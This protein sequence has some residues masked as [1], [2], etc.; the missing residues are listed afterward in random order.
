MEWF[1]GSWEGFARTVVFAIL[2]YLAFVLIVKMSGNRTLSRMNTFDFILSIAIGSLLGRTI[3]AKDVALE[4]GVAAL[5]VLILMHLL[6]VQL[7]VRHQTIRS[8]VQPE[9][10]LLVYNGTYLEERMHKNR[11]VK[12]DIQEALRHH[13]VASLDEVDAVVLENDGRFSVVIKKEIATKD[14]L[15]PLLHQ[16]HK[17]ARP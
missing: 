12:N 6:F 17:D 5:V 15:D 8:L 2:G 13:G 16:F 3:L 14:A 1:I 7:S 4:E 11:V 10:E 9:P